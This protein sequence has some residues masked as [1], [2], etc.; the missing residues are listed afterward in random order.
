MIIRSRVRLSLKML[1]EAW[2][3]FL[4]LDSQ[5][6]SK[7]GNN[8]WFNHQIEI[9]ADSGQIGHLFRSKSARCTGKS[10]TPGEGRGVE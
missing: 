6:Q 4:K 10:A 9:G 5:K 7:R 2:Q 3:Y 1:K 8:R